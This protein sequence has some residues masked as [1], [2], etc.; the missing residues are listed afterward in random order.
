MQPEIQRSTSAIYSQSLQ[1]VECV[2]QMCTDGS[3]PIATVV[4]SKWTTVFFVDRRPIRLRQFFATF[5]SIHNLTQRTQSML[6]RTAQSL[7]S[8]SIVIDACSHK[9]HQLTYHHIWATD[10]GIWGHRTRMAKWFWPRL[11]I[12]TGHQCVNTKCISTRNQRINVLDC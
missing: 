9:P 12:K 11:S 6:L 8:A 5:L 7:F 1:C 10:A 4:V 3:Q 2:H